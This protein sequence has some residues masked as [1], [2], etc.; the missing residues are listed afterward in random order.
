LRFC[1]HIEGNFE[2]LS[3][4]SQCLRLHWLALKYN[5]SLKQFHKIWDCTL[6]ETSEQ[7]GVYEKET[8]EW[9]GLKYYRQC[10]LM[11]SDNP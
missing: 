7:M 9:M 10:T 3:D 8:G 5:N 11:L 4:E 1:T 2:L 6:K